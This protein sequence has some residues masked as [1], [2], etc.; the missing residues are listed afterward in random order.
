MLA[1]ESLLAVSAR[2][3]LRFRAAWPARVLLKSTAV[4][5]SSLP[6]G[7]VAPTADA[8]SSVLRGRLCVPS[9]T[10][11]P[12]R[13]PASRQATRWAATLTGRG[14]RGGSSI[15]RRPQAGRHGAVSTLWLQRC[16]PW[17][18]RRCAKGGAPPTQRE[19]LNGGGW[20]RRVTAWLPPRGYRG[21][22]GGDLH[23]RAPRTGVG[24]GECPSRQCHTPFLPRHAS[25]PSSAVGW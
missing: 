3:T 8:P 25:L 12:R 23:V 13:L 22:G 16:T 2:A 10:R 4:V 11:A 5:L 24:A 18:Q 1:W 15:T 9:P 6:Y 17:R 7:A 21:R 19:W 20:R 14:R